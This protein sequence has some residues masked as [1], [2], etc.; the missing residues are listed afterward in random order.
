MRNIYS[1]F[2]MSIILFGCVEEDVVSNAVTF[3]PSFLLEV[4]EGEESIHEIKLE[5]AGQVNQLSTVELTVSN[6]EYLTTD[7]PLE[8]GKITLQFDETNKASLFLLKVAEESFTESY[9]SEITVNDFDGDIKG[10]VKKAFTIRVYNND[11]DAID[12]ISENFNSCDTDF[13]EGWIRYSAKSDADFECSGDGR[14]ASGATG[15]FAMEMT[16]FG[17]N[18]AGDDWLITPPL[19]LSSGSSVM[20]FNSLLRYDGSTVNVM[21][22]SNYP[23]IGDPNKATW[24]NLTSATNALDNNTGSWDFVNSGQVDLS[25]YVGTY[26]VGFHYTSIGTG[27]GQVS[28]FRLDDFVLDPVG[29]EFYGLPFTDDLNAC[30]DFSI[31]STFIQERVPGSKQDR[32]WE[33]N[34]DGE[35]G[36]QGLKV[37]ALGGVAGTVDAWLIS[38]KAFDLSSV[39]EAILSF[40][41][42]S[43]AAGSGEVKIMYSED[44]SGSGDP[45]DASWTEL[46]VTMPAAGSDTYESVEVDMLSAIGKTAYL[47]FQFVGGTNTSSVAYEI[48]NISVSS[49]GNSGGG[50]GGGSST[51]DAGNC[52]L[53]GTGTVIVSHDFE[54]CTEDFSVP[55]GFIEAVV[56]GF[57]TDRGWGCRA[58]GTDG[59]RG[60]RA[61]A[62]GGEDGEDNAWL[63]MD[64]FDATPYSEISLTFD[65][66]SPFS[67]PGDLLVLY[68]SDYSGSG[69]PTSASWAQL[70]NIASQLPAQG[71]SVFATVTTSPCDLSGSSV[72]IAFQYINGTSG[73][74]SAWSIDNL[75][76]A[77]N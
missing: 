62:F 33:C 11:F 9:N 34:G 40:D 23:A 14:G 38:A 4:N 36:S 35:S 55:N 77:G 73:A 32:G 6:W 68:S 28:T 75:V 52:T 54:G 64:S 13:P 24:T 51:T 61:S 74:S 1:L 76:L 72:Y 57:K 20:S 44:Y 30:G 70:D 53:T 45:T 8:N 69:D 71:A 60:V 19:D 27:S 37:S 10:S 58:D 67:G 7:P 26:F 2:I 3:Y 48:D 41:G 47:A 43:S 65:V 63:I 12:A 21:I 15:D 25:S 50:G 49:G 31:P 39:S 18:E 16:A 66:Q 17:S 59:S 42:K 5:V 56:P 22:S 29:S 46:A